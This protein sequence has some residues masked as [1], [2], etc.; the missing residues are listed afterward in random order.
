MI[1][2][3]PLMTKLLP[4]SP[5]VKL[6]FNSMGS[7]DW[8]GKRLNEIVPARTNKRVVRIRGKGRGARIDVQDFQ[9]PECK[10]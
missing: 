7:G 10:K 5:H 6:D 9:H 4:Q 2:A 8:N 1:L 3:I